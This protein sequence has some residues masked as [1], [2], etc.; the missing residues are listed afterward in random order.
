MCFGIRI[1]SPF[2]IPTQIIPFKKPNFPK[3]GGKM[4]VRTWFLECPP[5]DYPNVK[6]L[7]QHPS[8]GCWALA[9]VT[10]KVAPSCCPQSLTRLQSM[11]LMVLEEAVIPT[12]VQVGRAF[13]ELEEHSKNYVCMFFFSFLG[14]FGLWIDIIWMAR[15]NQ[16]ETLISKHMWKGKIW[17]LE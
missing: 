14:Q 15:W 1:S 2:H 5:A 12:A 4:H 3:M 6:L 10:C 11:Q 13:Q 8:S 7:V 9:S 16:I 17:L